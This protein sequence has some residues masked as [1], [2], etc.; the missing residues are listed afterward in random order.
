MK[1]ILYVVSTLKSA[2]PTNQLSYIIKYLDK[3]KFDPTILTL[4]PESTDSRK[5]YFE[6]VLNV[7]VE[8]LGL[9][10]IKGFI[11]AKTKVKRF[12]DDNCIDI[13]HSQ[14]FRADGIIHKLNAVS[15][16]ATLR[17]YPFYDNTMTYG[18]FRGYLMAKIH[19]YYLRHIDYP[20]VVSKSISKLLSKKNN[21]DISYI[22]NGV[23]IEKFKD[24]DK[25]KLRKKLNIKDG[26]KIFI[27]V[28]TLDS[29]KDPITIIKAFIKAKIKSSKLILLGNGYL[30]KECQN[31]IGQ[32]KNIMLIGNVDNVK[33]YLGA[34]DYFVSSSL[35]EGLPNAVL[36]AMICGLPC[37]LSNIPPHSELVEIGDKFSNLF[38]VKN[39]EM[40]VNIFKSLNDH[41]YNKM[42]LA[43]KNIILEHLNAHKMSKKYQNVYSELVGS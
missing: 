41:E 33:E 16:V 30:I 31:E 4:S 23:D 8:T 17:N 24:I 14:G 32:N 26:E 22:Q 21:F 11:Y 28:G 5:N 42:S 37:I 27:S 18:Q 3:K 38:E 15:T 40:L 34:S 39:I 25:S 36:E 10:R 29:R 9:S 7:K 12:I 20:I 2:G 35:A 6:D 43:G 13:V 19:L 1:K